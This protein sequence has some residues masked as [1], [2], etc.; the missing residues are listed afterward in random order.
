MQLFFLA[1]LNAVNHFEI[2]TQRANHQAFKPH[3]FHSPKT[4]HPGLAVLPAEEEDDKGIIENST[5][6]E[7][8]FYSCLT[9]GKTKKQNPV[10]SLQAGSALKG[11]SW[12]RAE[13]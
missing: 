12:V 1:L 7:E 4:V 5:V 6:Q 13:Q 11:K 10:D 8:G 9:C 3:V 2:Y